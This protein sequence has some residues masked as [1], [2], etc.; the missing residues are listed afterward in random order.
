MK[1]GFDIA[2]IGGGLAGIC[3]AIAAAQ[4]GKKVVLINE[5]PVWGG[6]A[7][8]ECYVPGHGAEAMAHNRN[9]RD[10][11]ILEDMRLDYYL[12]ASP[13]SDSRNYYD[14]ILA[15]Y[16]EK[17]KNLT[18]LPHTKVFESSKTGNKITGIKALDLQTE[19][20]YDIE[21]AYFVDDTGDGWLAANVG[22]DFRMGREGRD[23]FNEQV[24]GKDKADT[25]TLGCSIYGFAVKRDYPVPFKKPDWAISYDSCASLSHRPHDHTHLFP[26]ITSSNDQRNI[27]FFWWLEWGGQLDV[28]KDIDK[29]YQ[30]LLCELFGLWDHL[31]NSCTPETIKKLECFELTSWSPFPLKRES[32]RIMG[33][34]ILNENDLFYPK[35]FEDRI[36]F[37]GW[38]LDDHPPEG[39]ASTDPACDQVF[40]YEPY[41]VPYRSCYSKDIDN[42]F[43]AG[44]CISVT[45]GALA[46]VRVMNTLGI[47]GEAVGAAAA[48]CCDH[49]CTPREL[50]QKHIHELQQKIL[51]RD[52]YLIDMKSTNPRNKAGRAGV[53]VS[54]ERELKGVEDVQDRIELKWDTALQLPVSTNQIDKFS[55][56]LESEKDASVTW[57]IY[58][59]KKLALVEGR[60]LASGTVETGRG[61]QW[62]ELLTEPIPVA[63]GEILTV[64]LKFAPGVYWLYGSEAYQTRW[65]VKYIDKGDSMVYHG[66][67]RMAPT[68]REWTFIN[69]HGRLPASLDQWLKGKA[70]KNIHGKLF[71][72]PAFKVEPPQKPYGG[73]NLINGVT[74]SE[75]WPNIWISDA[76]VQQHAVLTWDREEEIKQVE[77][78][79]DTQLDYSDQKYGFPRGRQDNT[80]PQVIGETVK[81]FDIEYLEGENWKSATQCRDNKYRRWIKNFDIPLRTKAIRFISRDTWGVSYVGVYEIKVF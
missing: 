44:R 65:G 56:F 7:S 9:C 45:H 80:M 4:E 42:L 58:R 52:L 41:S 76:G 48:L 77:I 54:S 16:C 35:L 17:E 39:I 66:R 74:R 71:V 43:I 3:A 32:R 60:A 20:F 30:H 73:E 31:K 70:G 33:D 25:K 6:N 59:N 81:N 78:I 69:H 79:F 37:G 10:G 57:E 34:Y 28:I 50:G 47:L 40:L 12:S 75:S 53:S 36:G 15:K 64:V 24:F 49:S 72:T 5:R 51:D 67:A 18:L 55:V 13:Y 23:E 27:Q 14:L 22:A 62:Y 19:E 2:V 11:G 1:L 26:T 68:D 8:S 21:A 46:S 63:H 29:I 61:K 38:P